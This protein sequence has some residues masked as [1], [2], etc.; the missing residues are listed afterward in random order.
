[1][2]CITLY[3]FLFFLGEKI[4]LLSAQTKYTVVDAKK[5]HK[6]KEQLLKE[7]LTKLKQIQQ[8][9]KINLDKSLTKQVS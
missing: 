3:L 7:N 8:A 1:M 4:N 2:I 5:Q 6:S 9:T